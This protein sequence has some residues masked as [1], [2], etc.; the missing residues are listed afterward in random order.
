M[1]KC[2]LNNEEWNSFTQI[3]DFVREINNKKCI[4]TKRASLVAPKLSSSVGV[5]EKNRSESC[6]WTDCSYNTNPLLDCRLVLNKSEL[7]T[8]Y[9]LDLGYKP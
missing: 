1:Y 2:T 6:A 9:S 4:A 3:E 8:G 5:R 7:P